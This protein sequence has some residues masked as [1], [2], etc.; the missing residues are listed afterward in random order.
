MTNVLRVLV[1]GGEWGA[2]YLAHFERAETTT[3]RHGPWRSYSPATSARSLGGQLDLSD[4]NF[5]N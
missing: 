4:L 5:I 1:G 2:V 3:T